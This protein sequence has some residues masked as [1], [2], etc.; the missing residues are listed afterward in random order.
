[1][2]ESPRMDR[3]CLGAIVLAVLLALVLLTAGTACP[4]TPRPA[5]DTLGI[6][7]DYADTLF[8]PTYVHRINLLV[9]DAGWQ[10]MVSHAMEEQYILCDAEIDGELIRSVAIRPKGNSSLAAIA[11][12]GSDRFS[13]KVEFDHY[14]P[15]STFRGLDKL[16]LNNL[17]QD[18]SCMK[19]SLTYRMM[20][21]MGVAAPLSAY[22][23]V[24]RN[25]VDLGLYLAVE[26]IEDSFRARCLGGEAQLYRPDVYAIESITPAAFVDAPNAEIFQLDVDT[27]TPGD[28]VDALG[29]IINLAFASLADQARISA[30]GYAGDDPDTYRVVFDTAVF[31]L[32]DA[33]RSRYIHAVQT[34]CASAHP[35]DAL[36]AE[37]LASYFAVHNFVNNYDSYTGIFAHNF[38]ISEQ[39]GRLSLVPWDY[40]LAFGAFSAESAYK[41][42]ARDSQWYQPMSLGASMHTEKSFVNYPID[43]P[44]MSAE[45]ADRPLLGRLL[46]APSGMAMYHRA[47]SDLLARYFDGGL[48]RAMVTDTAAMLRPYVA[49]GLTFYTPDAFETAVDGVLRYGLLRAESIS[50]QLDGSIP[51]TMAGQQRDHAHLVDP[52]D[53]DLSRTIDFGGLAFGIT[54]EEVCAILNAVFDG[55]ETADVDVLM[56]DLTEDPGRIAAMAGRIL[57]SSRLISGALLRAAAPPLA[58]LL[59]LIV[60]IAAIRRVKRRNRPCS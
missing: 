15:G 46:D 30:G 25:G 57:S 38:Y 58:L 51:A 7:Q 32:T 59:S 11:G 31:D 22:A 53:L 34:L 16:A 10:Y 48:Y 39:D 37:A 19:D 24:Q 6:S 52:G 33:A 36:D 9:S 55:Y 14:L 49:Q 17:G 56:Q 12:A 28:R 29:P 35:L 43:T 41:C 44:L 20:N 5:P 1:M 54:P 13:F 50:G 8:D 18:I 45:M 27:L 60:L 3:L 42:F 4:R 21:G 47:M 2:I 26:G 23:L 40:N